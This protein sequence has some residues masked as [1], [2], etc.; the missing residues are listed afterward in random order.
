IPTDADF[1]QAL[2]AAASI[3]APARPLSVLPPPAQ[4]PKKRAPHADGTSSGPLVVPAE[5]RGGAAS[6]PAPVPTTARADRAEG[7]GSPA[8]GP[9]SLPLSAFSRPPVPLT[10]APVT[11]QDSS[12]GTSASGSAP[13]SSLPRT[14]TAAAGQEERTIRV[15]ADR[16]RSLLNLVGEV[17]ID[18][19]RF[20]KKIERSLELQRLIRENRD[21][22]LRLVQNFQSQFDFT[23]L[24]DS[25]KRTEA[26]YLMNARR[27]PV[28]NLKSINGTASAA[29]AASSTDSAVLT[30]APEFSAL[31]MDH[32]DELNILSRSLTEAADDIGE[33]M[34]DLEDLFDSF[35]QDNRKFAIN[36]RLMQG[37]ITALS[38]VPVNTVFRRLVRA[39]RDATRVEGREADL[40]FV[41]EA[42]MLD[43][44]IVDQLY[45]PLLHLV[46][47]A[48]AHG[49]E[50]PDQRVAMGKPRRGTV[51][52]R[53]AQASS[54][55]T[56]EIQDDGAGI[57]TEAVR[58]RA[59]E[60]GLLA[61]DAPP[62][63]HEHTVHLLFQPGFST[64]EKISTVAGR[65]VGLDVV[66]AEIESL[67]GAVRVDT[68]E[69]AGSTWV[70]RL[71]ISLSITEAIIGEAA[72]HTFAF[73][74]NFIERGVLM[75]SLAVVQRDGGEFT[76]MQDE[77]VRVF[78]LAEQMQL[79][80]A[81]T[82]N[83]P[84][85]ENGAATSATL[86]G[87]QG[88]MLSV[89]ESRAV[90][91]LDRILR[92][93]EIVVKPL[94]PLLAQHP[95][96]NGATID[97][98]GHPVFIINLPG[99]IRAVAEPS[100]STATVNAPETKAEAEVQSDHTKT[101]ATVTEPKPASPAPP[102]AAIASATPKKASGPLEILVVDDSLSVRKVQERTLTAMGF[103]VHLAVDG[104][105]ALDKLRQLPIDL[106]LSDLEMPRMNGYEFIRAVRN[107][108]EKERSTLPIVIITSRAAE[109]HHVK[110][111]ELGA[112]GY[113]TKPF[114]QPQ[115]EEMLK[116]Q[117][118]AKAGK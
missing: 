19:N 9:L 10:P 33:V 50:P 47:N 92:R 97:A 56:I 116:K 4:V 98:E 66:K 104:L 65:G 94:D 88:L 96:F 107:L 85:M 95:Y 45:A 5:A 86:P 82:E 71:P 115:L 48:V 35:E 22:L 55:V 74:L 40:V 26:A 90:L 25:R 37:E 18:R 42:T 57:R 43:K 68:T 1:T 63:S 76:A 78:S 58:R 79:K 23:S 41:G 62:L 16:L 70:L 83:T 39:F 8:T 101:A 11:S 49:I 14:P 69:G 24:A 77:E 103:R 20:E 38:M 113:L 13:S 84:K 2:K 32:Y 7:T 6:T 87:A 34:R 106:I 72:G 29:T 102:A 108:P 93:Q 52:M 54:Q 99:L 100:L 75:D 91:R 51:I 15:E 28:D 80:R 67:S 73:P 111:M 53:A 30:A 61:A 17:V 27:Q 60:R 44:N 64:A 46:R 109:K 81:A 112:T 117:M 89:G 118:G 31:E 110:A 3:R 12:A 105:D 114:T 59:I 36:S 21:H